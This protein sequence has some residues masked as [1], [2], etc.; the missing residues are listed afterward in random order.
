MALLNDR[1]ATPVNYEAL[2]Y[3]AQK[4]WGALYSFRSCLAHGSTPDF[5][6]SDFKPI[7]KIG[8]PDELRDF[9]ENVLKKLLVHTLSEP[10][11]VDAL[12]NC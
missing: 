11:L 9:T 3:S 7:G 10:D 1:F 6:D 8:G 2:G 5:K 4:V 12:K